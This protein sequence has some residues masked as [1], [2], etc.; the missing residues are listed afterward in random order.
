MKAKIFFI[1][2]SCHS[3]RS[4]SSVHRALS[5]C[6]G[7]HGLDSCRD[8][9]LFFVPCHARAMLINSLSSHLF[10]PF[11][12]HYW[13][14]QYHPYNTNM[15]Y[16]KIYLAVRRHKNQIQVLQVQQVAHASKMAFLPASQDRQSLSSTYSISRE[17]G[18]LFALHNLFDFH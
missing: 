13:I 17:F 5:R 4:R 18:L 6:S 10:A 1:R 9:H 12:S 7:G 3:A 15:V 2:R 11:Y 14:Y 16:I 8:S